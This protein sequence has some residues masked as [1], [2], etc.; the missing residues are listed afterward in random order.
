MSVRGATVRTHQ[1][2]SKEADNGKTVIRKATDTHSEANAK[3]GYSK[4][5]DGVGDAPYLVPEPRN[6]CRATV[7]GMIG[8]TGSSSAY[9]KTVSPHTQR[10]CCV[11]FGAGPLALNT[12]DNRAFAEQPS[13]IRTLLRGLEREYEQTVGMAATRPASDQD[14]P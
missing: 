13:A 5:A 9:G 10:H 2:L 3:L 12:R 7:L 14:E 11:S 8:R 4:Y 1:P 6:R